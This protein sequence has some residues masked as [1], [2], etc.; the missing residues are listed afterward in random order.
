MSA[1]NFSPAVSQNPPRTGPPPRP[2]FPPPKLDTSRISRKWL[3]LAYGHESPSQRLDI[4]LPELGNGPFPVIVAMH[5]GAFKGG[6]KGDMQVNPMLSGLQH[7]YAVTSIN[8]RLSGEAIFPA[9]IRDCKAA[10]RFLRANAARYRLD[11]DRIAVWGASAG[12]HLAALVGTSPWVRELDEPGAADLGVS[13]AVQAV[14][15]W[16][17]PV[18]D[19]LKM[20][21]EFHRSGLGT[22]DHSAEDSPESLLMGK[23]ITEIPEF[24]RMASP[25]TYITEEVPPFL[26]QHGAVDH[27]VPVEQSIEFAAVM[28]RIAG[29]ARVTLEVLPEV[30]HHGDPAFETEENI[31]HV[32]AFLDRCFSLPQ[33]QP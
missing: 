11:P 33:V 6:D 2:P 14:V 17:G 25:M 1:N 30:Y 7:G 32:L 28:A 10:V 4:Y 20:D 23:K 29:P 24:V 13:C 9:P 31:Q 16:S 3:E 22:P 5:G 19:F 27:I 21:E 18:E 8:Y 26:I 12:A 15:L